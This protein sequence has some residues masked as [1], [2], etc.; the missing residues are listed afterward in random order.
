MTRTRVGFSGG[1]EVVQVD[2]DKKTVSFD[3][4]LNL[5]WASHDPT[6]SNNSR[7]YQKAVF[8]HNE[9]QRLTAKRSLQEQAE[10]LGRP[11]TSTIEPVQFSIARES[12]QK[13]YLRHDAVLWK[14][15]KQHYPKTTGVTD[16]AAAAKVNGYLGGFSNRELFQRYAPSLGLS[17]SALKR[18]GKK[19]PEKAGHYLPK[20]SLPRAEP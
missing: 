7:L 15:F 16:S 13:Y 5:F 11:I 12:E 17:D 9:S 14:E 8:Y 18:L 10:K 20:C 1:A 19:V 4:L 6:S 2:F 3:E